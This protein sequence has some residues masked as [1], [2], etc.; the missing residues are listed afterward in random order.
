[1]LSTKGSKPHL[2]NRAFKCVKLKTL[3][4]LCDALITIHFCTSYM[5]DTYFFSA[6]LIKR[7]SIINHI[8]VSQSEKKKPSLL[9]PMSSANG[10]L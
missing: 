4:Y 1:M 3:G 7:H 2:L 5:N 9:S 8:D 6:F 10:D